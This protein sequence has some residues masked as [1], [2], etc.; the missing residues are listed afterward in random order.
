MADTVS[1]A[2]TETTVDTN[3]DSIVSIRDVTNLISMKAA[4]V[5]D[6]SQPLNI[7]TFR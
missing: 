1:E 2:G 3:C 7:P 5:T 4:G 6:N